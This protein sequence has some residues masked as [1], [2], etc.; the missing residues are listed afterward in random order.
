MKSLNTTASNTAA[1]NTTAQSEA[2]LR[3]PVFSASI[4]HGLHLLEADAGTGKTWTL[5]G[6]IVRAII[7]RNLG[8]DAVLAVTFTN[9]AV[10]ELKLRTRGRLLDMAAALETAAAL[11]SANPM[12]LAQAANSHAPGDPFITTYCNQIAA[13]AIHD[14]HGALIS[15]ELALRRI[16]LALARSDELA[17]FT[18]HG[19]C[20]RLLSS[21]PLLT[22]T[23][24]DLKP[25]AD[26]TAPIASATRDW[27][28]THVLT[29]P[30]ADAS[31]LLS[32]GLRLKN[33]IDAVTQRL[34]DPLSV[35]LEAAGDWRG[36][37][38]QAIAA[39]LALAEAVQGDRERVMEWFG[40][41]KSG[42]AKIDGRLFPRKSTVKHLAILL[43]FSRADRM[44]PWPAESLDY[45]SSARLARQ[46]ANLPMLAQLSL[47][48][49]CDDLLSQYDE[50]LNPIFAALVN[51]CLHSVR[52]QLETGRFNQAELSYDD[53]IRLTHEALSDAGNGARLAAGIRQRYAFALLDECQ[54]TDPMQWSILRKIWP[55][56]NGRASDSDSDPDSQTDSSTKSKTIAREG[57][58]LVG[59][60]KQSIY[61]FRGA[62][63]YAY[64]EARSHWG[65]RRSDLAVAAI[66]PALARLD[67]NQRSDPALLAGI[68]AIFQVPESFL[69]P[70]IQYRNSRPGA[71]PRAVFTTKATASESDAR[72]SFCW[73]QWSRPGKPDVHTIAQA[74]ASEIRSL[75]QPGR[76]AIDGKP[77][78]P[79]D[80]AVL[81]GRHDEGR[82]VKSA[83]KDLG[84]GAV[85]ITREQVT[86]SDEAYELLRI[87]AAI[88]SPG[89]TPLLRGALATRAL[90]VAFAELELGLVEH[91]V[92]F[93]QA[94]LLW[95]IQ[96]PRAAL[97]VLFR[98][99]DSAARLAS[100]VHA[101]RVLTNHSHMLDLLAGAE[102]AKS[103]ASLGLRWLQRVIDQEER[104]DVES[105]ELELRLESDSDL[106]RILTLHKSKG[107]EFPVVFVPFA[108]GSRRRGTHS[109]GLRFHRPAP[110]DLDVEPD[111]SR[112]QAVIDLNFKHRSAS[113]AHQQE[114]ELAERLRLLYVAVTRARHRCYLFAPPLAPPASALAPSAPALATSTQPLAPLAPAS[115]PLKD[116]ASNQSAIDYLMSLYSPEHLRDALKVITRLD[117]D[118]LFAVEVIDSA[119]TKALAPPLRLAQLQR[120]LFRSWQTSSY[121]GILA[122]AQNAAQAGQHNPRDRDQW[123]GAPVQSPKQPL[124]QPQ[125]KPQSPTVNAV[126][127]GFPAGANA[128]ACLHR[129]LEEADFRRGIDATRAARTLASYGLPSQLAPELVSWLNQ[130]LN[131]ELGVPG[132]RLSQIAP[133]DCRVE[134]EFNLR[135]SG[136]GNADLVA[137][138]ERT[139]PIDLDLPSRPWRGFLNGFIDLI[140]RFEGRYYL[141]D[142]K[143]NWLGDSA[144]D[145]GADGMTAAIREHAYALQYSIYQLA[146]HRHLTL[147]LTDYDPARHLGGVFY[148]F[149]RG[150]GAAPELPGASQAG[151]YYRM[152]NLELLQQLDGLFLADDRQLGR[153][154]IPG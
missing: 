152:P 82:A 151:I 126:R 110:S 127:F 71:R 136:L 63:I 97:S 146:L 124:A 23:A 148:L 150:V 45:F 19:F 22:R 129:I 112:W 15:P 78:A 84:L 50:Q 7:E 106:V 49:R 103:S 93:E 83:L 5:T 70:Q 89:E 79:N 37:L 128:G 54:D 67:E 86:T 114:E 26:G 99:F 27:W 61:R 68:N 118:E 120:R 113:L 154:E 134:L 115:K 32:L 17:A 4:L 14:E 122:S 72:G 41:G 144:A 75:L 149:I 40:A 65:P 92:L 53:L 18:L 34:I 51:E 98:H 111:Q 69:I 95:P 131:T 43:E 46:G 48:R 10:A 30:L 56:D 137:A 24:P 42:K 33:L 36:C 101:E 12:E 66:R 90:G 100:G 141:L 31:L 77:L 81:V 96:G 142:W 94:R 104:P 132:L 8:I 147:R 47:V 80:I 64:L 2:D 20:Q 76:T 133:A 119:V 109:A 135:V 117:I 62:D 85:E 105:D 74:C 38:E 39:R 16:R 11:E 130:V 145:Y 9:A 59:D 73:V 107:L 21:Q 138:I 139:E 123:V 60:P 87:I 88:A 140:F 108:W 1:L 55:M 125:P 57:L 91:A 102:Q 3:H 116:S 35:V 28:R 44:L 52:R 121:S 153:A 13:A 6:L 58:V 29:L 143:S 25:V